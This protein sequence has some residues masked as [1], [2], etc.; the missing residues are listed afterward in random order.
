MWVPFIFTPPSGLLWR[1]YPSP[2]RAFPLCWDIIWKAF[3]PAWYH[4]FIWW[5][6]IYLSIYVDRWYYVFIMTS[7]SLQI[8]SGDPG[9]SC[10]IVCNTFG[11]FVW[12]IILVFNFY[13][14]TSYSYRISHIS[15][16]MCIVVSS[17]AR[18]L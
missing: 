16:K 9:I 13:S 4:S 3:L 18:P 8:N 15:N 10:S 5:C 2:F 11:L 17:H 14:F 12:E 6:V 7:G 1:N